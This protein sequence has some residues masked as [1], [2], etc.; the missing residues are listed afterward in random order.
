M[1]RSQ[2]ILQRVVEK[3]RDNL[4]RV[5]FII[6]AAAI[7]ASPQCFQVGQ[8]LFSAGVDL[9]GD[10][11]LYF[12]IS[13]LENL[14]FPVLHALVLRPRSGRIVAALTTGYLTLMVPVCVANFILLFGLLL[15]CGSITLNSLSRCILGLVVILVPL[16][17]CI[18][19]LWE[20]YNDISSVAKHRAKIRVVKDAFSGHRVDTGTRML[21][22]SP[23]LLPLTTLFYFMIKLIS[24]HYT[25]AGAS[26]ALLL[27]LALY[28]PDL[29]RLHLHYLGIF[30]SPAQPKPSSLPTL[31]VELWVIIIEIVIDA[32]E[33]FA[34]NCHPQDLPRYLYFYHMRIHRYIP[35][36]DPYQRSEQL[37]KQLRLVSRTWKKILEQNSDRWSRLRLRDRD[38]HPQ[39]QR[40]DMIL[41]S[42]SKSGSFWVE[43]DRDSRILPFSNSSSSKVTILAITDPSTVPQ[44][45]EEM[46]PTFCEIL[47]G[48]SERIKSL[49]Y[50]AGRVQLTPKAISRLSSSFTSLGTLVLECHRV[51]GTVLLP[52][53]HTLGLVTGSCNLDGWQ[54]PSLRQLSLYS[55]S[56]G[57]PLTGGHVDG[58]MPLQF[59]DLQALIIMPFTA[60]LDADFWTRYP[61]LQ[62]FGCGYMRLVDQ[63]P[64]DHP[65]K[66]IYVGRKAYTSDPEL[67]STIFRHLQGRNRTLYIDPPTSVLS[68]K[69]WHSWLQFYEDCQVSGIAWRSINQII[70]PKF[71]WAPFIREGWVSWLERV[72]VGWIPE[73]NIAFSLAVVYRFF[74][75]MKEFGITGL[76]EVSLIASTFIV[77]SSLLYGFV[78]IITA[79]RRI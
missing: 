29:C 52:H 36:W 62:L 41:P 4:S 19:Y 27:T 7:I 49:S 22:R 60:L 72:L 1:L 69:Y 31:P 9:S 79:P 71:A 2:K 39:T 45:V 3:T 59:G 35:T 67:L 61:K 77:Y 11:T 51:E 63:P 74:H 6:L 58:V 25:F 70:D 40:I 42:N 55:T 66:H 16:S 14:G 23:F 53:L 28:R 54:C 20:L 73:I 17:C 46:T 43:R 33:Y 75:P 76:W 5:L 32:P 12:G 68:H 38:I 18:E 24:A 65:L 37:R 30:T 44:M 78:D 57:G 13:V 47:P 21:L 8:L 10:W 34:T 26:V 56:S 15:L 64:S 48:V 50:S